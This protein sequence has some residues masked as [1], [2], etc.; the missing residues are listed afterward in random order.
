MSNKIFGD[1]YLGKNE[2]RTFFGLQNF[3]I[4]DDNQFMR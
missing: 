4:R 2:A 1:S 3:N